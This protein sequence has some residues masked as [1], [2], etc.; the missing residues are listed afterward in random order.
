MADNEVGSD[1]TE[2]SIEPQE[3]SAPPPSQCNSVQQRLCE[4]QP[5]QDQCLQPEKE[6]QQQTTQAAVEEPKDE[7][8]VSERSV[9]LCTVC[10]LYETL[11]R[12]HAA[13]P[14]H[15][16]DCY[17]KSEVVGR[18]R[19]GRVV[20]TP[21]RYVPTMDSTERGQLDLTEL[22]QE[23]LAAVEEG[24]T[25]DITSVGEEEEESEKELD[26]ELAVAEPTEADKKFL[27][28]PRK[29]KRAEDAWEEPV[30]ENY[31][32]TPE[33]LK[34]MEEEDEMD[35]TETDDED[36]IADPADGSE[37]KEEVEEEEEEEEGEEQDDEEE[38]VEEEAEEKPKAKT[39]LK[40]KSKTVKSK[41]R[42]RSKPKSNPRS[43]AKSKPTVKSTTKPKAGRKAKAAAA[44]N[45]G[46]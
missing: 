30:D 39:R 38:D 41:T 6:G 10:A 22:D 26:A 17:G 33:E 28:P 5:V 42:R 7:C 1:Q 27:A 23:E 45:T 43:N 2:V 14:A 21:A 16:L 11:P 29:R 8:A 20:R 31:S 19:S 15:V 40:V 44:A 24:D 12:V 46:E 34:A 32:P 13:Q 36:T 18:T 9:Q 25:D 3:P 35:R 4:Q 37:D